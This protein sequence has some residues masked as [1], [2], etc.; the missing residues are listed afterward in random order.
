M[1][2]TTHDLL[3]EDFELGNYIKD[4]IVPRAVLYYTGDAFDD[5]DE[6]YEDCE[7]EEVVE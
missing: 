1:D 7:E 4:R 6:D 3:T 5:E 2:D